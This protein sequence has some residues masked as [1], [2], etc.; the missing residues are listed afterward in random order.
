MTFFPSNPINCKYTFLHSNGVTRVFFS[1][2]YPHF[3]KSISS[4]SSGKKPG[5]IAFSYL[6]SIVGLYKNG[7]NCKWVETFVPFIPCS[8]DQRF[9]SAVSVEV[10]RVACLSRCWF[11]YAV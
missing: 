7:W 1:Q 8:C 5:L 10:V 9:L 6:L 3:S 11:V 4:P 2:R